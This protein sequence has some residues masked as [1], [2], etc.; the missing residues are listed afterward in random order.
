M[1]NLYGD[2]DLGG[3]NVRAIV[4][5]PDGAIKAK[6]KRLSRAPD[7]LDATL[8][9]ME[10][11]LQAACAS[12]A[13]SITE[14]AGVGIASPGWVNIEDGVVPAAPQLPGWRDVP[15]VAIMTERLGVPVTLENDANAGALGENV[16]G[17]GRGARHLL[18][19]T[20]STGIG[21]G[22]VIEGKPYGG[23]R[24]SAGEIGHTVIDPAGPPCPCGNNGCLEVLA[25]GTAIARSADEAVVQGRSVALAAIKEREG[26]LA[27]RFVAD[28][29][30]QGDRVSREIYAEAGRYLGISLGNAVNLLSPEII[31]IGGGVAQAATLFLPQAEE[32]MRSVALSEPL[33]H[34]RLAVSELGDNVGVLGMVAKL[35]QADSGK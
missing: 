12:A 27:A 13:V 8:E 4:A 33:R 9:S 26:R 11:C 7:G 18:Y 6:D 10:A 17:A 29:A 34:V 35:N 15:L 22:L 32:T 16:F 5:T 20:V 1:T 21:G 25:S 19:V 30:T 14:L 23:A 24:G 31:V 2:I 28:A 3:T